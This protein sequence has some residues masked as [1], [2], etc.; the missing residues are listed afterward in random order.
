MTTIVCQHF[1][2]AERLGRLK[3]KTVWEQKLVSREALNSIVSNRSF[4][5]KIIKEETNYTYNVY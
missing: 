2:T 3:R 1:Q 4:S 5:L